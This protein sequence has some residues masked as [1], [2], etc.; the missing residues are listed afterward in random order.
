MQWMNLLI[1]G[2]LSGRKIGMTSGALVS[3][4]LRLQ[5]RGNGGAIC[6]L[7]IHDISSFT[8]ETL[9]KFQYSMVY[10]ALRN[11]YPQLKYEALIFTASD[12]P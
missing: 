3:D 10:R 9:L 2:V 12:A 8:A 6:Y 1:M 7:R 4:S 5:K 11:S